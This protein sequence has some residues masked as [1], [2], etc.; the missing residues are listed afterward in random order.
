MLGQTDD[1]VISFLIYCQREKKQKLTPEQTRYVTEASSYVAIDIHPLQKH[2]DYV[3]E[4]LATLT[5]INR[6]EFDGKH[7]L[8]IFGVL[9]ALFLKPSL[10]LY[11]GLKTAAS[12][13]LKRMAALSTL[14]SKPFTKRILLHFL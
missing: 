14:Q 13:H 12:P 8:V 9:D 6:L 2:R 3:S 5:A 4:V 10:P 11:L 1:E 7:R